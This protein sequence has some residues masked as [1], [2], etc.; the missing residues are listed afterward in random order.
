MQ[1]RGSTKSENK[2]ETKT[3]EL[4]VFRVIENTDGGDCGVTLFRNYE[5]ALIYARGIVET[6]MENLSGTG[7]SIDVSRHTFKDKNGQ[8]YELKQ[9]HEDS[10]EKAQTIIMTAEYVRE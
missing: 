3:E 6:L 4:L 9:W 8:E 10:Y 2:V 1:T 7:T 5:G